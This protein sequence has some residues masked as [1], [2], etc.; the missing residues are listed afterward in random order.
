MK[1]KKKEL[2]VDYIGGQGSLTIAEEQELH[3][4]FTK[5]KVDSKKSKS[6]ASPKKTKQTKVSA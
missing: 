2:S 1:T 6:K 3:E 5:Q 4:Y